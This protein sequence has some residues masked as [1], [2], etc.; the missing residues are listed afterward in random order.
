MGEFKYEVKEKFAT[1]SDKNGY[2]KEFNLISYNDREPTYDIRTWSVDEEG[3]R[4]MGK[5][6]TLNKK[7]LK[8][9]LNILQDLDLEE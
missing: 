8:E 3:E 5:G 9:L 7:E 1:L 6:I 2:T 4:K